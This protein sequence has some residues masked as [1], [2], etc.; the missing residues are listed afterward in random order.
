MHHRGS[1]WWAKIPGIGTKPVAI[2]SADMLNWALE[3]VTVARVTA[4]ERKRTLPT[5]V[6]LDTDEV[7]GLPERSFILCHNIFTL[8][9]AILT[10]QIGDVPA[11]RILDIEDALRA[12]L[13]L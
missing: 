8:P 1:L 7:T 2:V 6:M 5:H 9:K 10:E 12:A 3:E 4:V 13:D 11:S